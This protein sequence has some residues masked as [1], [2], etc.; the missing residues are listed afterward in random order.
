MKNIEVSQKYLL[1]V[2]ND[3]GGVAPIGSLRIRAFMVASGI[4]ELVLDDIVSLS[5]NQVTVKQE[6][7]SDKEYLRSIYNKIST[8]KS[9]HL[10]KLGRELISKRELFKELFNSVGDSLVELDVVTKTNGGILGQSSHYIGSENS[11]KQ[12]VEQMRAELLEEG[13]VTTDTVVLSS[14]LIGSRTLKNYFSKFEDK[15][16]NDKLTMLRKD[17]RNKEIFALID[18]ISHTITTII[19]SVG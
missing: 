7:P 18:S 12:I 5:D 15:D 19:A 16:L 6:L 13:P 2:L 8:E 11:K 10:K 3:K 9:I 1:L 14:L 17:T 4:L